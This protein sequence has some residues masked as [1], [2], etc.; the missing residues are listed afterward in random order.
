MTSAGVVR[1]RAASA[2]PEVDSWDEL[3][4]RLQARDLQRLLDM[5]E[6][7]AY[8]LMRDLADAG[9]ALRRG[10]KILLNRDRFRSWWES[11]DLRVVS[12]S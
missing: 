5:G 12:S 8:E 4:L 11:G 10:K 7:Q 2:L 3:P 9:I 1:I 6:N